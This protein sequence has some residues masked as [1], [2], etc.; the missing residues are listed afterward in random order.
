MEGLNTS[1]V[2]MIHALGHHIQALHIHDNDGHGDHHQLPFTMSI[3]FAAVV[4]ALKDI[5]Y[6]RWLTL[7]TYC[8]PIGATPEN[9][10]ERVQNMANAAKKIA[11]MME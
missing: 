2:E 9:I 11:R 3:D 6:N 10:F 4:Q 5:G 8:Y 7:E 1:P